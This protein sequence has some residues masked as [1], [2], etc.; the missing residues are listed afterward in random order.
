MR[1]GVMSKTDPLRGYTGLGFQDVIWFAYTVY[2]V[3][4][5]T[6]DIP[7]I[8]SWAF[9]TALTGWVFG[10]HYSTAAYTSRI[11]L[12]AARQATDRNMAMTVKACVITHAIFLLSALATSVLVIGYADDINKMHI[13]YLIVSGI[14]MLLNALF[15]V[16]IMG[17][18]KR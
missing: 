8:M 14:Y 15:A 12:H 13:G 18:V 6:T 5:M 16:L 10:L 2:T 17:D 4:T 1:N 3:N 11:N 7:I 9:A